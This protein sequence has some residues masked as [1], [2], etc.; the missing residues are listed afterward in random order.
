MIKFENVVL[1]SSEQWLS[2]IMGTRNPLN[3][4]DRSDSE[5]TFNSKY[6]G[7]G[8]NDFDL[9]MRLSR[10]GTDHRKFMRMIVVYVDITA[11]MY[12][13]T[14][15][16]TYKVGTVL[17]STSKM[18]RLTYKPFE[19]SDFSFEHLI[20][21]KSEAFFGSDKV[22]SLV[23]NLNQ[24]RNYYLE[25]KDKHYWYSILQLLP[26]S[27]NQKR[28]VM[29]NYEVLANIYKSRKGH[30]LDEWKEFCEWIES[31]PY[32]ELITGKSN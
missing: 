12:W 4:W 21:N 25:T 2:I 1:P 20:C 16:D 24:L 14:E 23:D 10:A 19:I 6:P 5:F 9:M 3:S 28:T 15:F 26:C 18:H 13:L 29:L 30:K 27:Y 17:N 22:K 31:L 7:L 32:S 8:S 11:P